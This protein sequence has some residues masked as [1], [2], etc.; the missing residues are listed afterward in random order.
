MRIKLV[1]IRC[2]EKRSKIFRISSRSR[3]QYSI[4]D[5]APISSACV[6][7][8]TR[9]EEMRCNSTS[10][11]RIYCARFGTSSPSSFSTARQYT[12]L[13]PSGFR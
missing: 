3:K 9:C 11:T 8:H 7:S 1:I 5:I 6:P 2:P 4:T 12:R 10:I 13:F